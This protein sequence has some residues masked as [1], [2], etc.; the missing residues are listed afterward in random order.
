METLVIA[1]HAA[2]LVGAL[3]ASVE[4]GLTAEDLLK[5]G[6]R[7]RPALRLVAGETPP[8]PRRDSDRPRTAA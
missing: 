7:P 1:F 8:A 4:R 2:W 3:A 5:R 6:L